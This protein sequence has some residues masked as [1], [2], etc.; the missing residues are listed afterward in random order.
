MLFTILGIVFVLIGIGLLIAEFHTPGLGILLIVGAISLILGIV[1][2]FEGGPIVIEI[3]W[4]VIALLIILILALIG[5]AIW[6][7]M[8]SYRRQATTG[9]EDIVGKKALVKEALSPEGTVLFQ[10]ELWAAVSESGTLQPGEEVVITKVD[11]FKL[12]VK[13]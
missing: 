4:W 12:S 11:G 3:N 8:V 5:Y 7:I 10:G 1:L 6:R 2:L 9:K 13:K